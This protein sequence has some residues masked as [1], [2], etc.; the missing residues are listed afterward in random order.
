VRA[1]L[2]ARPR[3]R[4]HFTPTSSS[5]LNLVERWFANSPTR[6]WAVVVPQHPDL[7]PKYRV[8]VAAH[9]DDP[10][11]FIWTTRDDDIL[12]EAAHHGVALQAV[13]NDEIHNQERSA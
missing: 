8:C 12:A 2:D 3:S 11:P 5:W 9:N 1:W 4:M 10:K 7:I 13:A 6:H